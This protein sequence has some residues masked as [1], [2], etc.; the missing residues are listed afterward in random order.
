VSADGHLVGCDRSF[1]TVVFPT[2]KETFLGFL[3]QGPYRTTP[4]RD[5]I[6]EH[7]PS[8]QVLVR[9]TAALLT[10]VLRELRDGGLLTM[11]VLTALPIDAARFPPGSMFR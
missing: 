4:A 6:P 8:N 11:E 1:L 7:D 9:E 2:E 5:N 3:V 10:D